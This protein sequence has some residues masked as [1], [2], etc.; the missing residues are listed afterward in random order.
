M[1]LRRI[2]YIKIP[3]NEAPPRGNSVVAYSSIEDHTRSSGAAER[4][5]QPTESHCSNM[6]EC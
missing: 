4:G 2:E 5:P 6:M 1:E 3:G